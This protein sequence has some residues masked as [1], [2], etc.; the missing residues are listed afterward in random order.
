MEEV[1]Q[2]DL[3]WTHTKNIANCHIKRSFSTYIIQKDI[4]R[5]LL[6]LTGFY[7]EIVYIIWCMRARSACMK[8]AQVS[9]LKFLNE[10]LSLGAIVLQNADGG[11]PAFIKVRK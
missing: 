2:R 4:L 9:F 11:Q 8:R 6:Y 7:Q 10:W 1:K 3:R 5:R